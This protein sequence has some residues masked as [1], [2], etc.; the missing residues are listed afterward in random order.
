MVRFSPLG[1]GRLMVSFDRDYRLV[2]FYYSKSQA[3]NHSGG[4]PFYFGIS[5]DGKFTWVKAD[6]IK[7]R[8]YEDHT[9]VSLSVF[10]FENVRFECEDFVDVYEDVYCRK[11]TI[12]NERNS[13]SAVALFFHQNFN[14]YGNNI[15]DTALYYP[16]LSSILHYK[17]RRYFLCS[18]LDE[19]SNKMDQFAI[20]IKDFLGLEGTW[21]DAE[22][23]QLSMNTVAIGSVDSVIRHTIRLDPQKT[24]QVFYFIICARDLD[25]V[26][27]IYLKTDYQRLI[28]MQN[29][30]FNYWKLWCNKEPLFLDDE[31][32]NLY[33]KSLFI[34]RSHMN[35]LGGILASSDS[36]ILRSH[37]DGYYYVWPRDAA[38]S[39]YALIQANHSGPARKFFDFARD[40]VSGDGYFYHKYGPDGKVASSWLPRLIKGRSI[41]PIQE[42]ETNL[43]L[44]ALYKHFEK[45]ND[46]E[47]ISEF[48]EPIV[49]KCADF[50][51][52]FSENGLPKESF[53]IW[54]ERFGI[55][56]FTVTTAIA[57]LRSAAKLADTFGDSDYSQEYLEAA[58]TFA[59]NFEKK[60]FISDKGYYGRAI[61]DGA[62]DE[63]VDSSVTSVFLFNVKDANDEHVRT[64]M[65][66]I[67]A[68]LWVPGSGGIARYE[69]DRYHRI[70][71][72]PKIP[73]NPWVITTLWV[74]RYFIRVGNYQRARELIDWVASHRQES[75]ILPEQVDPYTGNPLSVSPLT[76]S[77]AEVI[78]SLRELEERVVSRALLN[79]M[80][81]ELAR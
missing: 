58:D 64:T 74:A 38:I 16:E 8:D 19:K 52:D 34:V 12:T 77:H 46:I 37:R 18:T 67:L 24:Q 36:E 10:D 72:D 7:K 76:W 69:G 3:E 1:N 5:V 25:S 73:G 62:L 68:R 2:D 44:W 20:G 9:M 15:G 17:G 49:R 78:I 48:Y 54:E 56:A 23:G 42:D 26:R 59:A 70:K 28:R 29:R 22:D 13:P 63:T 14:I 65:D 11:V 53:D 81:K 75:G 32:S 27:Q 41:L 43:V 80:N 60:F 51:L 66:A 47:Y 55:H 6:M 35:S 39:A 79:K 57:A 50:I 4:H 33:K 71:E 40:T 30:T 21:R 45:I 31:L 61:I